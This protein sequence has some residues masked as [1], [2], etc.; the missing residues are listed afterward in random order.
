MYTYLYVY[1]YMCVYIY[2]YI[3]I[4]I[5]MYMFVYI[6]IHIYIYVNINIFTY[7]CIHISV[8]TFSRLRAIYHQKWC[9][10]PKFF[11]PRVTL[12]LAIDF[13][14]FTLEYRVVF[15]NKTYLSANGPISTL[16]MYIGPGLFS[17]QRSHI[18]V[19]LDW[20]KIVLFSLVQSV[21]YS[22]V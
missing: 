9:E 12:I 15:A 1:I 11:P 21:H 14:H 17:Q 2:A 4:W 8:Y 13:G 3:H 16:A 18:C 19:Q 20:I 10:M 6:C 5:Y 7:L 22:V